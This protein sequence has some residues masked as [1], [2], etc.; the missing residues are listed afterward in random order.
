MPELGWEAMVVSLVPVDVGRPTLRSE[1]GEVVNGVCHWG[2]PIWETVKFFQDPKSGKI[3]EK[4]YQFL[5]SA[6]VSRTHPDLSITHFRFSVI[7]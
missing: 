7:D 6:A 4:A 3:N 2:K 1:K 5:V